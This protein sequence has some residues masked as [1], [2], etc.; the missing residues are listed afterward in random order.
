MR[1]IIKVC[2]GFY[3]LIMSVKD[4]KN[5]EIPL[6]LLASGIIFAPLF[7]M[8]DDRDGIIRYVTGM[9]PGIVFMIISFA[10]RGQLGQADAGVLICLGLCIGING[11]IAVISVS[12]TLIAFTAMIMLLTG[13]FN[14]KSTLPYIPFVLLGYIFYMFLA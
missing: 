12:L 8:S 11:A 7:I 2:F 6:L 5:R 14:R 1:M 9:I 10:S 4:I 13:K 3:L